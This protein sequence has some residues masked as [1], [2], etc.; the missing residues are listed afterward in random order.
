[1]M[2]NPPKKRNEPLVNKKFLGLLVI[3]IITVSCVLIALWVLINNET[4]PLLPENFLDVSYTNPFDGI[5]YTGYVFNNDRIVFSG[6]E[7]LDKLL[8]FKAQTMCMI[9]LIFTELWIVY[10]ARSIRKSVFQGIFNF[11]LTLM[12][13]IVLAILALITQYDLAQAYLNMVTLSPVD[14]GIALGASLTVVV[15][16]KV[17]KLIIR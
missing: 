4:Y 2:T 5:S 10:E 13:L 6:G 1:M 14:W 9:T 15:I 17:Y 16:S 8:E 3:Q 11:T 7:N 12:V